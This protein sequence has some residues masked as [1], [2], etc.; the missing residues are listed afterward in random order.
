MMPATEMML[1]TAGRAQGARIVEDNRDHQRREP[2][3][4]WHADQ[5][6]VQSAGVSRQAATVAIPWWSVS[7]S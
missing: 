2:V 1:A 5:D 6:V 4:Q 3:L 7:S